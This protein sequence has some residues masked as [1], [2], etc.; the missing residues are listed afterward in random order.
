VDSRILKRVGVVRTIRA[1]DQGLKDELV[2]RNSSEA[3]K[4]GIAGS[5]VYSK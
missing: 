3:G 2:D 1:G 5:L 4:K